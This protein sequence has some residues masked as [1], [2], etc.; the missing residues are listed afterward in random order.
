MIAVLSEILNFKIL[1]N[2]SFLLYAVRL[3]DVEV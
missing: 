1:K 3:V 2:S